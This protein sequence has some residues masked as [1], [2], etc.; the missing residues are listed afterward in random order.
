[1]SEIAPNPSKMTFFK[2][3]NVG[4]AKKLNLTIEKFSNVVKNIQDF[5]KNGGNKHY[6]KSSF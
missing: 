6:K 3:P 1:M 4:A 5:A 2:R